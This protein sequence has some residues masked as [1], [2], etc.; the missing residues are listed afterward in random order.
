MWDKLE[1]CEL[2]LGD[3]SRE[4]VITPCVGTG[5]TDI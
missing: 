1:E 2:E 4:M 3:D 5:N